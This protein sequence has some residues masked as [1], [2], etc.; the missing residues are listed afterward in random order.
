MDIVSYILAKKYTD[1]AIAASGAED[2]K[3]AY[4]I[5]VENGFKGTEQEW[6][7]SLSPYIGENG[8]WFIGDEDLGVS[9]DNSLIWGELKQGG[10]VV[11][12]TGTVDPWGDD[13]IVDYNAWD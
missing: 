9:A 5:A 11:D 3:S 7:K 4:E 13:G 1:K 2:G 6:L 10:N 12:G 8:N